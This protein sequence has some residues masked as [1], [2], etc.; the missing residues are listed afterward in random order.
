[1]QATVK[2]LTV[3]AVAAAALATTAGSS[4]AIMLEQ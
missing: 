1:M 3:L 4:Q 2:M